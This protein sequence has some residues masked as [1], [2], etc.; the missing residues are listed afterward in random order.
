MF[1]LEKAKQRMWELGGRVRK[2]LA[3][4]GFRS[5]AADGFASPGVVVVYGG[6][7]KDMIA[8]FK[9]QGLQLAGGV[10][11]KLGEDGYD[12]PIDSKTQTFRI[13]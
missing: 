7:H 11:W 10:P 1:G 4:R 5:V 12:T 9:Q 3:E 2:E 13:G 6:E 8:K